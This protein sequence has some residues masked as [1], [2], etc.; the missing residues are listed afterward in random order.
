MYT[1]VFLEN[2]NLLY[3][4]TFFNHNGGTSDSVEIVFIS[5]HYLCK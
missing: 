1:D 3:K 4:N 2:T 5:R